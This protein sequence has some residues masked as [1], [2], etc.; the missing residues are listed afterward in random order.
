MPPP[1]RRHLD[2]L[3]ACLDA[4]SMKE[5]A[6]ALGVEYGEMRWM[7]SRLYRQLGVTNLAQEVHACDERWPG[8]HRTTQVVVIHSQDAVIR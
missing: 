6:F 4:G 2:A 1:S 5:A 3:G 8:W 7:L